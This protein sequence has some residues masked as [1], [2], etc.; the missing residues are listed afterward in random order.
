MGIKFTIL[1]H[2]DMPFDEMIS[3]IV[4]S[5]RNLKKDGITESMEVPLPFLERI[6]NTRSRTV[7]DDAVS[8]LA[9]AL[10]DEGLLPTESQSRLMRVMSMA[11][12]DEIYFTVHELIA[13]LLEDT[14]PVGC[15]FHLK[16]AHEL[17]EYLG[18]PRREKLSKVSVETNRPSALFRKHVFS[19]GPT[20]FSFRATS[21]KESES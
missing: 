11:K 16:K 13:D 19:E 12:L 14:D 5:Y 1:F 6:L 10:A 4:E 9:I 7:I 8:N 17:R 3:K 20:E 18:L 15:D 2:K 21:G